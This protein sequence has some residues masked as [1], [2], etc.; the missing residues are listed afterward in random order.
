MAVSIVNT[1]TDGYA[2][3]TGFYFPR[4]AT[5]PVQLAVANAPGDWMIAVITIRQPVTGFGT[6]VTVSDDVHNWWEP[7]GAPTADS[8]PSGLVRTV[9]WAA[10]AARAASWVQVAPTGPYVSLAYAVYDV[11]GLGPG[12]SPAFIGQAHAS[13][14]T[15]LTTPGGSVAAQ[16]LVLTILG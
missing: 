10:P 15:S 5:G 6:S 3:P 2:P 4:S 14:A 16:S 13:S 11:A 7:V 9:I 8:S 12:W 1:W